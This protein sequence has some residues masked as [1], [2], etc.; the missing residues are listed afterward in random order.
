MTTGLS[1]WLWN[2]QLKTAYSNTVVFWQL[3]FNKSV[4]VPDVLKGQKGGH[5]EL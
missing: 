3:K 2:T 4:K 1:N 5:G